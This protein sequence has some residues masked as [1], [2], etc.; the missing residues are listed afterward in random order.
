MNFFS[1]IFF[2]F[3]LMFFLSYPKDLCTSRKNLNRLLRTE[4]DASTQNSHYLFVWL[5]PFRSLHNTVEWWTVSWTID[6]SG[7]CLCKF[8]RCRYVVRNAVSINCETARFYLLV[9]KLHSRFKTSG[10]IFRTGGERERGIGKIIYAR[11]P[12]EKFNLST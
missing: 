7:F 10:V 2:H 12:L 5:H 11:L 9:N 6:D 1:S 8:V 4:A 3:F